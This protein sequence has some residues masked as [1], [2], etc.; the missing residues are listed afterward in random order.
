MTPCLTRALGPCDPA[1]SPVRACGAQ[2]GS[3]SVLHGV[4]E[5]AMVV[6][7]VMVG[8]GVSVSDDKPAVGVADDQA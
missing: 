5:A 7:V 1:A 8:F 3:V 2:C 4:S 6:M